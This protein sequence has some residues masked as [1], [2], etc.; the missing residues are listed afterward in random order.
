LLFAIE[1]RKAI[2][3]VG[4][5]VYGTTIVALAVILTGGPSHAQ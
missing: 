3:G 4:F 1:L 5:K 2:Y